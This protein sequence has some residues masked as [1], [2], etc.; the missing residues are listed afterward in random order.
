MAATRPGKGRPFAPGP[1]E[2]GG[3]RI[4]LAA[5][6]GIRVKAGDSV[7]A[8]SGCLYKDV[9]MGWEEYGKD[10]GGAVRRL[11]NVN[12]IAVGEM[13]YHIPT[14]QAT[15][16]RPGPGPAPGPVPPPAPPGGAAPSKVLAVLGGTPVG[17][18]FVAG[19]DKVTKAKTGIY[20]VP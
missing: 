12:Q 1:Y 13:V 5:D 18:A 8:Y 15:N 20:E 2:H 16:Q 19:Y 10:A 9:L 7:S 6:G 14:W 11:D 4:N 17:K 3:F